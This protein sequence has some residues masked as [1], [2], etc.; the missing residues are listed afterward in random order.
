MVFLWQQDVR[1]VRCKYGIPE[2]LWLTLL[3]ST[4]QHTLLE[5][6]PRVCASH[7]MDM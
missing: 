6:T 5:L 1:M 4:A 7:G 2:G 3:T